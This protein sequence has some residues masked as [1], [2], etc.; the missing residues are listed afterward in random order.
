MPIS[1]VRKYA[2]CCIC[3]QIVFPIKIKNLVSVTRNQTYAYIT[4]HM[5]E[6]DIAYFVKQ[7]SIYFD[8]NFH[9]S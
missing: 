4:V 5:I 3:K 6:S 8:V 7:S 2:D 9:F 1:C